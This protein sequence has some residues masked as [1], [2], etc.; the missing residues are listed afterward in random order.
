MHLAGATGLE[1]NI[2]SH[3]RSGKR[4]YLKLSDSKTLYKNLL[5][6]A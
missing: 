5:I 1:N 2:P 3:R 6:N 4:N